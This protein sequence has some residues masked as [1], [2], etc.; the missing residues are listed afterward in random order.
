[1]LIIP[2]T[3]DYSLFSDVV[4]KF[5][6]VVVVV[7]I[8]ASLFGVYSVA[9]ITVQSYSPSQQLIFSDLL[10]NPLTSILANPNYM[11]P[12]TVLGCLTAIER[13]SSTTNRLYLIISVING[14]GVYLTNSRNAQ[15]GLIFGVTAVIAVRYI[16]YYLL[17]IGILLGVILTII[18]FLSYTQII[19]APEIIT[20]VNLRGR[21]VLWMAALSAISE[22]PILGWGPT[23][24]E[25]TLSPFIEN[26][27]HLTYLELDNSG[28]HNSYLRA[29]V[30]SGI[31]GGT[32]YIMTFVYLLINNSYYENEHIVGQLTSVVVMQIFSTASILGLS[33]TSLLWVLTVGYSQY[34][35]CADK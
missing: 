21:N 13:Y 25:Q 28:V 12:L 32:L 5:S 24:T 20:S 8:P 27:S 29:Y 18:V 7:G 3:I 19:D 35:M 14:F 4:S 10:Y 1:V 6:L 16:K 26:L 22:R 34:K 31:I 23:G 30:T 9:G 11:G 15:L 2:S 33:L 17:N